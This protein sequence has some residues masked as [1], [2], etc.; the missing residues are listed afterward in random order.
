M[1]FAVLMV[2]LAVQIMMAHR[3]LS[4]IHEYK[5]ETVL[6]QALLKREH[7]ERVDTQKAFQICMATLYERNPNWWSPNDG[8]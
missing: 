5:T 4:L 6:L 8:I 1:V 2:M 3:F 7:A